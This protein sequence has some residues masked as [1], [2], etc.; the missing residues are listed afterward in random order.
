M[1]TLKQ[2]AYFVAMISFVL[3]TGCSQNPSKLDKSSAQAI[4]D[5]LR[6]IKD[7]RTGLCFAAVA[8]R[9]TGSAQQNGMTITWVPCDKS[10][11]DQIAQEKD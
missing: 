8:S 7:R 2:V 1:K 5:K 4:A 10:V 3:L 6:Y 9:Q 11:E